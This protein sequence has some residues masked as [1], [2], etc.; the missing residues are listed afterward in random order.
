MRGLAWGIA[1]SPCLCRVAL[2]AITRFTALASTLARKRP[3]CA[4][5]PSWPG[6]GSRMSG[7]IT[8]PAAEIRCLAPDARVCR[9]ADVPVRGLALERIGRRGAKDRPGIPS[10]EAP[11]RVRAPV[12]ADPARQMAVF[13]DYVRSVPG[14]CRQPGVTLRPARANHVPMHID[15]GVG[16]R[17]I[18]CSM[19]EAPRIVLLEAPG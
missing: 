8:D 15:D 17:P 10:E 1:A 3:E 5:L 6:P 18:L 19:V 14:A 16:W 11:L 4:R 13:L 12:V 9:T 7:S 2:W